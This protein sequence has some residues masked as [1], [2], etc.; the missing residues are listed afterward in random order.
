MNAVTIAEPLQH[1]LQELRIKNAADIIKDY[2]MTE[3]LCKI[4][5]FSQETLSF[6]EKYR[7]TLAEAKT[8]YENGKE[9]FEQYDDLMEWEFAT[10]GK[11]Y[12][13]EQLEKLKHVL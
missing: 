9:D 12:W 5:D 10:Q 8:A 2:A 13:E 1:V 6:Q 11:K 4:S 7:L 3:I